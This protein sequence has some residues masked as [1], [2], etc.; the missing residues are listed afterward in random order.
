MDISVSSA[1]AVHVLGDGASIKIASMLSSHVH[2]GHCGAT[3]YESLQTN[4]RCGLS[5]AA[6]GEGDGRS[7]AKRLAVSGSWVVAR[8]R[9]SGEPARNNI[10]SFKGCI[11][12]CLACDAC[13]VVSFSHSAGDCSWYSD[14]MCVKSLKPHRAYVSVVVKAIAT[15]DSRAPMSDADLDRIAPPATSAWCAQLPPWREG[16]CDAVS[17]PVVQISPSPPELLH[18]RIHGLTPLCAGCRC[19]GVATVM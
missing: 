13:N 11:A 6:S 8:S 12:M 15:D 9:D 16:Y 5:F 10:S 4:A 19:R 7:R 3:M 17:R 1:V 14:R 18:V 2:R